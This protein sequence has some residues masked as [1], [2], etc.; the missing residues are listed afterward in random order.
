MN[1]RR[2]IRHTLLSTASG[3]EENLPPLVAPAREGRRSK[4]ERSLFRFAFAEE[5]SARPLLSGRAL[6]V[7]A[8]TSARPAVAVVAEVFH[9]KVQ[10]SKF[11]V[12]GSTFAAC[13]LKLETLNL[14]P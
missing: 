7:G 9:R 13:L 10:G 3:T 14:E 4:F 5:T 8:T 11:K 1:Q 6:L 12:Q 2:L